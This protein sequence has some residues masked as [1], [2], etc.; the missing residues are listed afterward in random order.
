MRFW[1]IFGCLHF[2]L[3]AV[4]SFAKYEHG[5]SL[6]KLMFLDVQRQVQ[7]TE[8]GQYEQILDHEIY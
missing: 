8:Y 2:L 7:R 1:N 6:R 5:N 4:K 3:A